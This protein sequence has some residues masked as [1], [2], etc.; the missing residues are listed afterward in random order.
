[1][2]IDSIFILICRDDEISKWMIECMNIYMWLRLINWSKDRS[3]RRP[4]AGLVVENY[5]KKE[6]EKWRYEESGG[7]ITV[8]GINLPG[9]DY[10]EWN[11][12]K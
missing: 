2:Y 4:Y 3:I 8:P 9:R 5:Y 7:F 1:M 12:M 11:E 6:R 10:D